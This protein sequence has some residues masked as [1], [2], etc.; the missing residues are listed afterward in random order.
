MKRDFADLLYKSQLLVDLM[1]QIPDVIYFK[2]RQGKLILVNRAHA[3]GLGLKPEE[4]IGKT[5]FD[6][7]PKERAELMAQDDRYVIKT[8][9]PIIDK[10]ERATRADGVD[11]YVSTTKI[12][13]FD[14]KG[15][16]VGLMG[17]TRDITRRMSFERLKEEKARIEKKIE[18]LEGLNKVKSEFVSIVSH[19]LRT[20]LAIIKQLVG[21]LFT[22]SQG[23]IN[24][25][26]REILKKA[27]ENTERLKN[28]VEEL[29]D[30]SRIESGKF[31]LHYALVNFNELIRD[32]SSYFRNLAQEKNISLSYCLPAKEINLFIDPE[33]INQVLSN[34]INNAI[35]FTDQGGKI[36]IEMKILEDKARVGVVDNGVGIAKSDL[37]QLFNKFVQ[38]SRIAGAERKGL[39]LG[40]SI[41]KELIKRHEGEIWVETKL[42]V[43][44]KFYFTLPRFYTTDVLDTQMKKRIDELLAK[45][46]KVHFINLHIVNYKEFK[47]TVKIRPKKLFSDLR[48]IID[49]SFRSIGRLRKGGS[50]ILKINTFKGKCS[51]ILPSATDD[52][53]KKVFGLLKDKIKRYFTKNKE[54]NIFI[55]LGILTFPPQESFRKV[56]NVSSNIFIKEI[57]IGSEMRRFKR[58]PYS[59]AVELMH[60]N[61]K[62]AAKTVDISEGGVCVLSNNVFKKDSQI[63]IRLELHKSKK[64]I[65]TK[66]RV[67]WQR[68]LPRLQEDIFDTYHVGLEFIN[69]RN[70]DKKNIYKEMNLLIK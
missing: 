22:E 68:K 43:G 44:S 40:L 59:A 56:K 64:S 26:Q 5:D 35:K 31:K 54:E 6:F 28:I 30:I 65:I 14:D 18:V 41:V 7:F 67:A 19:E 10:I 33:R 12:P 17:V 63:N 37:P 50:L 58:Y 34:L 52:E 11:N 25:K 4:V 2:D 51:I 48:T 32:S 16:V 55:A 66:V 20:P 3:K 45:G 23:P 8:G 61:I 39:G 60:G 53:I 70:N 15:N 1:D 46:V 62:E 13:R 47:K 24:D 21:L 38:V 57:Y 49:S 29:L 69:L 36:K 9:K 42:G 27:I